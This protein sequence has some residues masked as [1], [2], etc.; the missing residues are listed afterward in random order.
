MLAPFLTFPRAGVRRTAAVL[1]LSLALAGCTTRPPVPSGADGLSLPRQAHVTRQVS[2]QQEQD[3]VLVVQAEG[4]Q[5]TRWSMF[6]PF[7][8]PQARQIL[9]DG[10][11]RNDGFMRPNAGAS[12]LFS[13]I[14]FAW[15]PADRLDAAYPGGGWSEQ[16]PADGGRI[17]TLEADCKPRWTIHWRPG[18]PDSRFTIRL[19]DGTAWRVEPLKEA[20]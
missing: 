4:G 2:G 20:P 17:R 7:G 1:A 19:P 12:E 6:D 13:A 5:A 8:M 9:Q 3:A 15:L 16:R 18:A 10:T 11:W 14:L